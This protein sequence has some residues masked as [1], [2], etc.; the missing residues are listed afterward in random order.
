M[1]AD[2]RV[3]QILR[4]MN[5]LTYSPAL[6]AQVDAKVEVAFGSDC[7]TEIRAATVVCV[8]R[9]AGEDNMHSHFAH[10]RIHISAH[11]RTHIP[12]HIRT[13]IRNR[14]G[15][16]AAR[17]GHPAGGGGLAPVERRRDASGVP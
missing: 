2:Y 10:F 6:A 13:N 7:E 11:I 15:Y 16:S 4:N 8:D 9:I 17:C 1:F 5:I 14:S 12:V 3:P